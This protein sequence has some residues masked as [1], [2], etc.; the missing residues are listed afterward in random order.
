M[1]GDKKKQA[2]GKWDKAKG[3]AH[4]TAGDIKDTYRQDTD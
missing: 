3:E 4:K 1:T 2:A